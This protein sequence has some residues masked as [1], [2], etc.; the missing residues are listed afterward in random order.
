[1]N[2]AF[3]LYQLQKVDLQ[4]SQLQARMDE[5][6]ALIA[7]DERIVR[8]ENAIHQARLELEKARKT[9][10]EYE[11]TGKTIRLEIETNEAS[12]YSGKIRNPKELSDL[13]SKVNV[14]KKK[15]DQNDDAQ[16]E[17]MMQ[18]EVQEAGLAALTDQ[19]HQVQSQVAT[20]HSLLLGEK[21]QLQKQKET[22]D[23]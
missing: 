17:A 13:Q 15:R 20:S 10:R 5:I 3:H 18:I 22:L 21:S 1:M 12:M 6:D 4:I 8:A 7:R 19:L 16:I 9:L 23:V 2:Q 14:D 11:E